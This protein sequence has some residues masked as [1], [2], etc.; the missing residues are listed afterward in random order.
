M[1]APDKSLVAAVARKALDT[2]QKRAVLRYRGY[3]RAY[4]KDGKLTQNL[5]DIAQVELT[6]RGRKLC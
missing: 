2:R 5:D 4:D 6:P 1:K 3:F